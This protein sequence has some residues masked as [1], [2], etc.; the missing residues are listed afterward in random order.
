METLQIPTPPFTPHDPPLSSSSKLVARF[1]YP[2]SS[3]PADEGVGIE[4]AYKDGNGRVYV[5]KDVPPS[6]PKGQ[7]WL[8][9]YECVEPINVEDARGGLEECEAQV[10]AHSS[11]QSRLSWVERGLLLMGGPAFT[12][13]DRVNWCKDVVG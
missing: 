4:G 11:L 8:E 9:F 12:G 13:M 10:S 7:R 5:V 2:P 3:S 1:A 6:D